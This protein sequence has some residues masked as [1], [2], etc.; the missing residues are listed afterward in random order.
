VP[1]WSEAVHMGG[2]KRGATRDAC[3][4][5]Q[6][7]P[8]DNSAGEIRMCQSSLKQCIWMQQRGG[9]SV[10]LA[11]PG[12]HPGSQACREGQSGPAEYKGLRNEA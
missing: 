10:R 1:E 11:G 2:A 9:Q 12:P 6:C 8:R 5:L 3:R 4:A 7:I